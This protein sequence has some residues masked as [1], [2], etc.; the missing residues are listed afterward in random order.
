MKSSRQNQV[1]LKFE[2]LNCDLSELEF[3]KVEV[4][5]ETALIKVE[6]KIAFEEEISLVKE[7]DIWVL[8]KEKPAEESK[9]SDHKEKKDDHGKAHH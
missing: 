7:G 8:A 1:N 9:D 2:G 6:G 3:D 4:T 5:E